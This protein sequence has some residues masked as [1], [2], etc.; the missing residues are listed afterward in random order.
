MSLLIT[1]KALALLG[2]EPVANVMDSGW[3][4]VIGGQ[5]NSYYIKLLASNEWSFARKTVTLLQNTENTNPEWKYSF[6]LPSDYVRPITIY[7]NESYQHKVMNYIISDGAL[8]SNN[9]STQLRYIYFDLVNINRLPESVKLALAYSLV[10]DLNPRLIN[11]K[12]LVQYYGQKAAQS[13][14]IAI[15]DDSQSSN[16]GV[17]N[18]KFYT[19]I[20]RYL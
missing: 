17:T 9:E 1:N 5:V 12:S 7:H 20:R 2:A 16:S 6:A 3:S 18:G 11:D 13:L 10:D 19:N 4:Q 15:N 8:F 14:A